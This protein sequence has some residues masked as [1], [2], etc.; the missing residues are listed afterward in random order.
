MLRNFVRGGSLALLVLGVFLF[1]VEY[2]EPAYV[3]RTPVVERLLAERWR[4]SVVAR[5]PWIQAPVELAVGMPQFEADRRA[6]AADLVG[7]GQVTPERADSLA[8]F[9]VREAYRRRVPPALVFGVMLTENARLQSRAR[10]NV[11]AVGLM[12]VYPKVW[13]Q[14]LGK[15]FGT[16]LRDDR[17]NLRYGVYILSHFLYR[18]DSLSAG[19]DALTDVR[20]G[21]LRYNGCVRGTNTK[22]CHTYPDVVQRR[23]EQ[24]ARAQCADG[25]DRCVAEPLRVAMGD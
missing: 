21:L 18:A 13:R 14:A 16:D 19:D 7:T 1:S 12:Q 5:A 11:G 15:H 22:H 10:S 2:V 24:F 17:T 3:G 4:D 9:A 23:I 25:F 20:T 6:F 8:S